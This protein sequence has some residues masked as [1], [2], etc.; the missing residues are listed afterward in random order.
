MA[1]IPTIKS[2]DALIVKAFIAIFKGQKRPNK[3][4][5]YDLI[6]MFLENCVISD[7]SFWERMKFVE[8]DS[9]IFS[10]PKKM[11]LPIVFRK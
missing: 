4:C 3:T 9:L 8:E 5:I 7:D 6:K 1:S 2:S 11:K 10:K